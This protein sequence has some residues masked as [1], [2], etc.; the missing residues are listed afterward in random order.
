MAT[1]ERLDRSYRQ[2]ADERGVS[3]EFLQAVYQALG[4]APP[5]P[6][7]RAGED[8][9]TMLDIAELFRGGGVGDD[10]TLRLLACMPT[11]SAGSPRPRPSSTRPTSS[12][13]SAPPAWTSAG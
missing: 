10:A 7:A 13:A 9:I 8:D 1:P 11:A 4:F 2:L 12:G 6:A 3:V 5:E